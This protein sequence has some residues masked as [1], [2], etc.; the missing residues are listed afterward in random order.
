MKS[1]KLEVYQ[2]ARKFLRTHGVGVFSTQ[3]EHKNELFPFG[4]MCPYV[5]SLTG[6]IIIYVSDIAVHTKNFR[7]RSEVGFTV[8]EINE[9]KQ[10]ESARISVIGCGEFLNRD[11]KDFDLIRD[12][13]FS[14]FPSS[15]S[16]EEIHGF[17][18]LSIRPFR[19][20]YIQTFGRIFAFVGEE[21]LNE[22][23]SWTNSHREVIDHMNKDHK[24][25]LLVYCNHFL[26]EYPDDASLTRVD[27]E[28]FHIRFDDKNRY[29]PFLSPA[30]NVSDIRGKFI[31]MLGIGRKAL[32][33]ERRVSQL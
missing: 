1:S 12:I 10:Q 27:L 24:D 28:G 31:E 11:H 18:F 4:S 17:N 32:G 14:Q 30:T 2:D 26:G 29:I 5:I 22:R 16:Y 13:Y 6:E 15:K 7:K 21:L 19:V 33:T 23:P 9:K 20:H 25:A 3:Y 8:M